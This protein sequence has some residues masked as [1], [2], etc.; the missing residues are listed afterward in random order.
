MQEK[1]QVEALNL[2]ENIQA[3]YATL[4]LASSDLSIKQESP[5]EP[6][7]LYSVSLL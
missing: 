1:C 4:G 5:P 3:A 7:I 2:V 6:F